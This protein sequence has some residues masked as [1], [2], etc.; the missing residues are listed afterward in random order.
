[1]PQIVETDMWD[2]C[3]PDGP[4]EGSLDALELLAVSPMTWKNKLSLPIPL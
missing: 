4:P 3:K 2:S 1:V